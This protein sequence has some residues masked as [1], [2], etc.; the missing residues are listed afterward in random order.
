MEEIEFISS[1]ENDN[2]STK[3]LNVVKPNYSPVVNWLVRKGIFSSLKNAN[4]AMIVIIIALF[5]I[6]VGVFIVGSYYIENRAPLE[7]RSKYR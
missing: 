1:P 5:V 6:S 2:T 4:R 3:H 7:V